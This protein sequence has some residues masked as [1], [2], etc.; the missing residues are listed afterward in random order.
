M[1]HHGRVFRV[2]TQGPTRA[3]CRGFDTAS[4]TTCNSSGQGQLPSMLSMHEAASKRPFSVPCTFRN[5]EIQRQD[6]RRGV[7]LD[8][9]DLL[10]GGSLSDSRL[11]DCSHIL[12]FSWVLCFYQAL[13]W[14]KRPV[15]RQRV[16]ICLKQPLRL[17]PLL[18]WQDG[19]LQGQACLQRSAESVSLLGQHNTPASPSTFQDQG[20]EGVAPLAAES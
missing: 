13:P 10:R 9:S 8:G 4:A 11:G 17:F 18:L 7:H 6:L 19:C 14:L 12:I 20:Q 15:C 16:R 5:S 1:Q 2:N 3:S